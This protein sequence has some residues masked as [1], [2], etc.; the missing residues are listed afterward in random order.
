VG[1]DISA[2]AA[3]AGA[4]Y[5]GRRPLDPND[6]QPGGPSNRTITIHLTRDTLILVAALVFLAIAILLAVIFPPESTS[7]P[8]PSSTTVAQ[9]EATA[10]RQTAV[11]ATPD[12]QSPASTVQAPLPSGYPGPDKPTAEPTLAA[13]P[14]ESNEEPTVVP[15]FDP[16]RPTQSVPGPAGG[17]PNQGPYPPPN[18]T[19]IP[20]VA[21]PTLQPTA[22]SPPM[23]PSRHPRHRARSRLIS[24]S[25][26]RRHG[27]H[28][29]PRRSP[30]RPRFR[31][32]CC[33]AR[34]AGRRRKA[35]F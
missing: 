1:T 25:I 2:V 22:A 14:G 5:G 30:C 6:I 32:T 24:R 16:L 9:V 31:S 23:L 29:R 21:A 13:A 8:T 15:T 20:T 33:G 4:L 7:S 12:A 28:G 11:I 34:S 35:R 3:S 26:R 10:L 27:R 17:V 18:N 19:P